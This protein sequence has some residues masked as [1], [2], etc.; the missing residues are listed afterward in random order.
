MRHSKIHEIE[1]YGK[2]FEFDCSPLYLET[3]LH[4]FDS[5]ENFPPDLKL[6]FPKKLGDIHEE[7]WFSN[8]YS[9]SIGVV[10][11]LEGRLRFSSPEGRSHDYFSEMTFESIGRFNPPHGSN[12][13]SKISQIVGDALAY[14]KLAGLEPMPSKI[15]WQVCLPKSLKITDDFVLARFPP[16]E[17]A[18]GALWTLFTIDAAKQKVND[19][20]SPEDMDYINLGRFLAMHPYLEPIIFLPETSNIYVEGRKIVHIYGPAPENRVLPLPAKQRYFG[21]Y[22]YNSVEVTASAVDSAKL[23]RLELPKELDLFRLIYR[24]PYFLY[25]YSFD[26][27]YSSWSIELC[28][29]DFPPFLERNNIE[30]RIIAE[31]IGINKN[32]GRFKKG[33]VPEHLIDPS[34]CYMLDEPVK[35]FHIDIPDQDRWRKKATTLRWSGKNRYETFIEDSVLVNMVK[36]FDSR[37]CGVWR[38]IN[39]ASLDAHWTVIDWSKKPE[40]KSEQ[41]P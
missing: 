23:P 5:I 34:E 40:D 3:A 8:P 14:C 6:E 2:I 24:P 10:P 9:D 37:N 19:D 26:S 27:N 21:S 12:G 22:Y 13:L 15:D 17:P 25:Q 29:E 39:E 4:I 33:K 18:E 30:Y 1:R 36:D 11:T 38:Y 28:N 31:T 7:R 41:K 20:I 35:L 16:R 32:N